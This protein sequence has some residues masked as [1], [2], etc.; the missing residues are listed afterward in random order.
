MGIFMYTNHGV[1]DSLLTREFY[2][3]RGAIHFYSI[4]FMERENLTVRDVIYDVHNTKNIIHNVEYETYTTPS[5]SSKIDSLI[6]NTTVD[7]FDTFGKLDEY[8][9]MMFSPRYPAHIN[10]TS[11]RKSKKYN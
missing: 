7:I 11:L 9:G 4:I 10:P 8:I 5:P 2:P 6:T 1:T 3:E